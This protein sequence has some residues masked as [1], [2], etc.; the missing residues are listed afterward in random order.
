MSNDTVS[1]IWVKKTSRDPSPL[2]NEYIIDSV[3]WEAVGLGFG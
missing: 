3:N 1:R 2:I